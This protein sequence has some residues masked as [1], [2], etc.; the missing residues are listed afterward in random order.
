MN[1]R[2]QV[3]EPVL[4]SAD[5]DGITTL[6]LN[7]PEK[8]N[9]LSEQLL[10]GLQSE[11][12]RIAHDKSVRVVILAAAGRGFCS[13]HDLK[14]IR[15]IG[16]RAAIEMLFAKCSKMMM[17]ISSLPQPVIAKVHGLATAAGCQLVAACDLA[18]AST[19]AKFATPGVNMGAFCATPSVALGR[20][21]ARKH[22]M[23]MLLTAEMVSAERA[24]QIGL[25]NEVVTPEQLDLEVEE[26]ARL[27]T[28]KSAAAIATGKRIF[29]EQLAMPLDQAYALAGHAIAADF[30]G[31]D[32]KEG[33]EAFIEKR[34]PDFPSNRV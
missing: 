8:F 29:Y 14:E 16:D 28:T 4:L 10:D 33:V 2:D 7:R 13:G 5:V 19:L 27:L 31:A 34:H 9:S 25:V 30:V 32:A 21:V 22:A 18:I 12:D 15:S 11:F 1:A 17:T 20:N 23:H 26:L 6:T 3:T 24:M